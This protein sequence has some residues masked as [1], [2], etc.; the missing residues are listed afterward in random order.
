MLALEQVI[1]RLQHMQ[2]RDAA[3]LLHLADR[4]VA[5]ADGADLSLPEQRMHRLGG[6]FDRHQRVGPVN[7]VDV[8]MIGSKPAQ[9]ILD[10]AQD[11]RAAGIAEYS[12]VL[13]F[14]PGLGGNEHARAQAA[15]GNRLADESPRSGRTRKPGRYR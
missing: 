7:L 14:Q 12:S 4:K 13:P 8:D 5:D 10:L 3:E 9:G 2:R 11:P 15:L 6:F 1:G